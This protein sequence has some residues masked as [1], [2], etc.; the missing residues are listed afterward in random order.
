MIQGELRVINFGDENH[1]HVR[2]RYFGHSWRATLSRGK[3]LHPVMR[4]PKPHKRVEW[5]R[6]V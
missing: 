5:R 6:A 3:V 2:R 4:D 1:Y